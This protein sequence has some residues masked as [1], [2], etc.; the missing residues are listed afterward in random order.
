VTAIA[1]RRR[2]NPGRADAVFGLDRML[3]DEL[4]RLLESAGHHLPRLLPSVTP[5]PRVEVPVET[6]PP[7]VT[8]APVAPTL[9]RPARLRA[10][11]TLDARFDLPVSDDSPTI[12]EDSPRRRPPPPP[13]H[14]LARRPPRLPAPVAGAPRPFEHLALTVLLVFAF[15]LGVMVQLGPPTPPP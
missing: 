1:Y 12:P 9:L 10:K 3:E 6:L 14:P 5:P 7:L 4:H 13:R 8:P 11:L 15:V 2:D